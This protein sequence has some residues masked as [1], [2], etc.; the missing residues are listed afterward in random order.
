[1]LDI[2]TVTVLISSLERD[3]LCSSDVSSMTA[4]LAMMLFYD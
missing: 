4:T 1:M 3:V 2:L